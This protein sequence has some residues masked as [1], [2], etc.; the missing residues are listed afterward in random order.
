MKDGFTENLERLK[1][2]IKRLE[3]KV[4]VFENLRELRIY[5]L[6]T[7]LNRNSFLVE[8]RRQVILDLEAQGLSK[9]DISKVL[10]K[11]HATVLHALKS[12]ADPEVEKV[13]K[14]NYKQWIADKVYPESVSVT[15][16]SADHPSGF[17]S[18]VNYKLLKVRDEY[19]R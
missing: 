10:N 19:Y 16:V 15:V 3:H 11:N 18:K 1:N 17:R 2:E 5:L 12:P 9:F 14:S 7:R 4:E 8:L 13:V 6:A